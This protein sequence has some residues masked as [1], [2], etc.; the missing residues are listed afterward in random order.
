MRAAGRASAVRCRAVDLP[1]AAAPSPASAQELPSRH[2]RRRLAA[3][4]CAATM[5]RPAPP[6][7]PSPEPQRRHQRR[8]L[9][10]SAIVP[11]RGGCGAIERGPGDAAETAMVP[12]IDEK[13]DHLVPA[14]GLLGFGVVTAQAGQREGQQH[15]RSETHSHCSRRRGRRSRQAHKKRACRGLCL[16][17]GHIPCATLG[18]R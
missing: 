7:A 6:L 13:V 2:H 1:R 4:T 10:H 3:A 9:H 17:S 8:L 5:T 12:T 11:H 15:K 16:R 18:R 14:S